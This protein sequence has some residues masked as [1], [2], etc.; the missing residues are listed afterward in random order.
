MKQYSQTFH[1][2]LSDYEKAMNSEMSEMHS[3]IK[4]KDS[5]IAELE[6]TVKRLSENES[7]AKKKELQE[8]ND[9]NKKLRALI[10]TLKITNSSQQE[11]IHSQNSL[12]AS[13]QEEL[14][15][16][17]L[18]QEI[19]TKEFAELETQLN[20]LKRALTGIEQSL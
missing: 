5:T 6:A 10:E 12:I 9:E 15:I 7:E 1:Q 17:K 20:S 13:L 4:L 19:L 3:I 11:T 18:K 16:L 8:S 2:L 14:A